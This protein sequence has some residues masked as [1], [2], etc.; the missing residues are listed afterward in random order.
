MQLRYGS[1]AEARTVDRQQLE[2]GR[3]DGAPLPT[4]EEIIGRYPD[5]AVATCVFAPGSLVLGGP[6]PQAISTCT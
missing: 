5:L 4:Y 3:R 6:T 2:D 1:G